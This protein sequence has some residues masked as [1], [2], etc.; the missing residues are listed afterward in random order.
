MIMITDG[1][2]GETHQARQIVNR[3]HE[4]SASCSFVRVGPFDPPGLRVFKFIF[5]FSCIICQITIIDPAALCRVCTLYRI[6]LIVLVIVF[7]GIYNYFQ[8]IKPYKPAGHYG[9]GYVPNIS[10]LRF[11]A[12]AS[13]GQYWDWG[14]KHEIKVELVF[15]WSFFH[16][17]PDIRGLTQ[18]TVESSYLMNASLISTIARKIFEGFKICDIDVRSQGC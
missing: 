6:Q 18:K 7:N 12:D 2:I 10:L 16:D 9:F 4:H 15:R 13:D 11:I 5:C 14:K 17:P 3:L 1:V 8:T